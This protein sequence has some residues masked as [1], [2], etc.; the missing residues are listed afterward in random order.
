MTRP[1]KGPT[2]DGTLG[3]DSGGAEEAGDIIT[4][5]LR[6]FSEGMEVEE[7]TKSLEQPVLLTASTL[8]P[9]IIITISL[10]T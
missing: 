10:L 9:V 2:T 5:D 4:V 7:P 6:K 1:V 3:S 8:P